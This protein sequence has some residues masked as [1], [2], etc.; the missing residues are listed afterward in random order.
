M[1]HRPG[2]AY[3]VWLFWDGPERRL[4]RWYVNL[5]A[6]YRRTRGGIDT[7]DHELDLWSA[8]GRTWQVKD[9][10]LLDARVA[11]GRFTA[12]EVAAIRQLGARLR[13]QLADGGRWWD[14]HWAEWRPDAGWPVPELPPDWDQA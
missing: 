13:S 11:E 7:L 6:P 9:E 10:E 4:A 12:Q 1:L 3:S 5:Q 8:D 2:D 14:E